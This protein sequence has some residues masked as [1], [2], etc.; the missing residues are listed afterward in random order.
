MTTR[1]NSPR[2]DGAGT[3][4]AE[5]DAERAER[6]RMADEA[7]RPLR[8]AIAALQA[9]RTE[10]YNSRRVEC[11]ECGHLGRGLPDQCPC[12]AGPKSRPVD[13]RREYAAAREENRR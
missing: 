7:N 9:A 2:Y 11:D 12:C 13:D 5:T 3:H 1:T 6:A 10:H 8:E 4:R